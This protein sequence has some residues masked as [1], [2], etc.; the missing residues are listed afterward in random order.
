VVPHVESGPEGVP[1]VA[2]GRLD[3]DVLKR[4]LLSRPFITEF[5]ATPPDRARF[6]DPVIVCRAF[7]TWRPA[8]SVM[9]CT[10]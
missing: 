3:E 1:G 8:S 9:A 10:A 7:A 5:R 4:G 2:G 6:L